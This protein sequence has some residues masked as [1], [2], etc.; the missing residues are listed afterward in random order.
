MA[1]I[2]YRSGDSALLKSIERTALGVVGQFILLIVLFDVFCLFL[3]GNDPVIAPLL[4]TLLAGLIICFSIMVIGYYP[5]VRI[6]ILSLN[7]RPV[8]TKN[9]SGHSSFITSSRETHYSFQKKFDTSGYSGYVWTNPSSHVQQSDLSD[10]VQ[11]N[12]SDESDS[13]KIDELVRNLKE[14][15]SKLD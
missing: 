13:D 5:G 6:I 1:K 15:V 8:K 9:R 11:M 10:N 3:F 14:R 2:T 12:E 7:P 4:I